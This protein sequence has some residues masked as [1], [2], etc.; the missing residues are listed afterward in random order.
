MVMCSDY[1]LCILLLSSWLYKSQ[2]MRTVPSWSLLPTHWNPTKPDTSPRALDTSPALS[3][4]H[5]PVSN[6][7]DGAS[8]PCID[9]NSE[10]LVPASSTPD[11]WN[12]WSS[13]PGMALGTDVDAEEHDENIRI[14]VGHDESPGLTGGEVSFAQKLCSLLASTKT[15]R[16]PREDTYTPE[17]EIFFL[18]CFVWA[19][20]VN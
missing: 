7:G 13:S 14:V 6:S 4:G 20:T 5:S 18:N 1:I 8:A 16:L 9:E 12:G 11:L 3:P 19:L 10:E 2:Y 15:G 17:S